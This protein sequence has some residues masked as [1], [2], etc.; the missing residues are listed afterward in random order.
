MPEEEVKK[1]DSRTKNMYLTIDWTNYL[2]QEID[3]NSGKYDS[4][5]RYTTMLYYGVLNVGSNEFGPINVPEMLF[6]VITLI[7]SSMLTATIFGDVASLVL[8]FSM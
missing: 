5:F 7:F 6:C 1:W 8:I 3:T 4:L 2:E